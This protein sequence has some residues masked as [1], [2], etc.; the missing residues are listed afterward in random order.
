MS[1]WYNR[2]V[3]A[4]PASAQKFTKTLLKLYRILPDFIFQ[5]CQSRFPEDYSQTLSADVFHKGL[6]FAN[7]FT[8]GLH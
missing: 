1:W 4:I 2:T 6:S 3:V 8:P 7:D 5:T